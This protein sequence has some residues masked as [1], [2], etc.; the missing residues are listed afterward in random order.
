MTTIE[1]RGVYRHAAHP[2]AASD[3]FFRCGLAVAALVVMLAAVLL[4]AP[5]SPDVAML[6]AP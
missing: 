2:L 4:S 1:Y 3:A 6:V 5:V